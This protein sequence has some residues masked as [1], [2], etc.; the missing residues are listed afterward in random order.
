MLDGLLIQAT[1]SVLS[2][3]ATARSRVLQPILLGLFGVLFQVHLIVYPI[4]PRTGNEMVLVVGTVAF[5]QLNRVAFDPID[6]ADLFAARCDDGACGP[7]LRGGP[8]WL[9]EEH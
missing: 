1:S 2:A 7:G 8:P 4:N 6:D 9:L 5:C 3:A